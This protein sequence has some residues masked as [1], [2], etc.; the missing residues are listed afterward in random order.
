MHRSLLLAAVAISGLVLSATAVGAP[1]TPKPAKLTF[2]GKPPTSKT[3]PVGQALRRVHQHARSRQSAIRSPAGCW[4]YADRV[5]LSST[6]KTR[7]RVS[8][9]GRIKCSKGRPLT[10]TLTVSLLRRKGGV[11]R[12]VGDR[13]GKFV[14]RPLPKTV[15]TSSKEKIKCKRKAKYRSELG[16]VTVEYIPQYKRVYALAG[17]NSFP[18]NRYC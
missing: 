4:L 15:K 6:P 1:A 12:S 2:A 3:D 5:H 14:T 13:D 18:S 10:A 11:F 7:G 8:A 16:A 9:P 17:R